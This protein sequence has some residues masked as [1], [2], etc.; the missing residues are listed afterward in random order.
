MAFKNGIIDLRSDTLTQPTPEMRQAMYDAEVG[1]DY[2]RDDP[3]VIKLEEKAAEL[4]EREAALL[5]FS[6]TLGNS[7]SILAQTQSCAGYLAH[8]PGFER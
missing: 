2:Y 8:P 3:T 4:F 5:V 7:V 6:G 1:D